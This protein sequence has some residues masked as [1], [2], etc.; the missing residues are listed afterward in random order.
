M[1]GIALGH[2]RKSNGMIFYCPHNKQLYTSSDYK[3]DEGRSTP[4]TFNLWYDGGIFVGLYNNN[5]PTTSTEPYPEGMPVSFPICSPHLGSSPV[6]MRGT[7]ISVPMSFV[8]L[9]VPFTRSFISLMVPFTRSPRTSSHPSSP[10]LFPHPQN[11]TFLPGLGIPRKSCTYIMGN[12]SR[13]SWSGTLII[14][15]G[16]FPNI[17]AMGPN[18]LVSPFLTSAH[19]T[20]IALMMVP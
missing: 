16:V 9:M 19:P 18:S 12:T 15:P 1:Q 17:A 20:S 2:C 7:V 3:L 8:S 11:S 14:S 10:T 6:Y 4:T 5:S 13:A